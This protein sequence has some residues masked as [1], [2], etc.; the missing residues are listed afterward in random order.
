MIVQLNSPFLPGC[1]REECTVYTPSNP[2]TKGGNCFSYTQAK[3][4]KL[5]TMKLKVFKTSTST[6]CTCITFKLQ[7]CHAEYKV[8]FSLNHIVPSSA[9]PVMYILL[10]AE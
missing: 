2:D 9:D 4:S 10:T 7:E 8:F 6:T 3:H 5:S 1:K